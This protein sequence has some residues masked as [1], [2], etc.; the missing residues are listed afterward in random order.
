MPQRL[1]SWG[2]L[3]PEVPDAPEHKPGDRLRP[4]APPLEGSFWAAKGLRVVN[5]SYGL[6]HA[7][8]VDDRGGVW[9]W[10]SSDPTPRQLPCRSKIASLA[11]TDSSLYAV[12]SRGKVL[13][14]RDLAS[15]P[16]SGPPAEPPPLGGDLAKVAAAS[17]A[18]GAGHVLVVGKKGELVGLGDNRRGQ[19]GLGDPA[20]RPSCSQPT[21]LPPLGAPAV[22]AACGGEHS[23]ALL[24]DGS[25]VSFGDDRHLQL[26][27]RTSS[28]KDLRRGENA[29]STPRPVE[30]M[31]GRRRRW[32]T[33]GR[34]ASVERSA[35]SASLAAVYEGAARSC[36]PQSAASAALRLAGACTARLRPPQRC[37]LSLCSGT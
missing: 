9:A 4:K 10:G 33:T 18:A 6:R 8:A 7:A 35:P 28:V 19:L 5:M 30:Q 24:A 26:G 17:V 34:P 25:C 32:W 27:Q 29:V 31:R 23:V 16:S 3:V 20:A 14:W 13:E 22:A 11:C 12:T 1:F 15:A 21:L 2:A 37:P 36:A